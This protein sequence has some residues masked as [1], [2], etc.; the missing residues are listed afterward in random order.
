MR[1]RSNQG[2][3]MSKRR[4]TELRIEDL[5]FICYWKK[6]FGGERLF[7]SLIGNDIF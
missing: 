5:G 7:L 2:E 1:T 6:V 3:I 4:R